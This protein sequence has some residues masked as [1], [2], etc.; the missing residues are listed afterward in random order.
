MRNLYFRLGIEPSAS[1]QEI[2]GAIARCTNSTVKADGTEVLLNPSR[3]RNYDRVHRT[4]CDIGTLRAH[5]GLS[6]GNNWRSPESG[7]FT[8]EPTHGLSLYDELVVKIKRFNK[9]SKVDGF[10]NS[11]R[12]FIT[13]IVRL[14]AV[15][16]AIVGVI[17]IISIWYEGSNSSRTPQRS[18]SS[19][20][21]PAFNEP[22]LQLPS[23][24]TI[25]R[26]TANQGV[27]PL[28]IKTSVGSNYLVKLEKISTG[29]NMLDVFIRGGSTIEIKVPLGI[30]RLKYAAG[31]TWYGYDHYFGPATR[32]SKADSNFRFYDDGYRVSGYTVTL[33]QVRDGNL[34]TSR[35]AAG[36]F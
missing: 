32:Y 21:Q 8:A 10:V 14:V 29:N 24:G 22:P 4:L 12:E 33:Y 7:D 20:Q 25:R 2:R 6:H 27:A 3:R 13:G 30:Y 36:Q 1:E 23:S 34:S 15:F 28:E 17:W 31:Q 9:K 18:Y 16:G 5:L 35:L 11:V 26:Y 19:P